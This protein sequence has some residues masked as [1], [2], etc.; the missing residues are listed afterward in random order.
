[1][2]FSVLAI[3]LV[4]VLFFLL[5]LQH[6]TVL[7]DVSRFY[8]EIEIGD[9][10]DYIT[11]GNVFIQPVEVITILDKKSNYIKYTVWNRKTGDIIERSCSA[12]DFYGLVCEYSLI[13]REKSV[14][15]NDRLRSL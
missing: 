1:M 14:K 6:K 5:Y 15:K 13:K 11:D 12:S 4:F 8:E 10:F 3:V 7:N 9:I 2:S